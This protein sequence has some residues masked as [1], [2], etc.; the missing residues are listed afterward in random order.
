MLVCSSMAGK[1]KKKMFLLL[2]EQFMFFFYKGS[3]CLGLG[4]P[5]SG[6]QVK[7][8]KWMVYEYLVRKGK[9]AEM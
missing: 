3:E 6:A 7:D 8:I 9:G 5:W 4:S 1:M 2:S